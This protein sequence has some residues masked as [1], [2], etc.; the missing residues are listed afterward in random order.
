MK[1]QKPR[2]YL[3]MGQRGASSRDRCSGECKGETG[4]MALKD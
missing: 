4:G 1:A 2:G 3:G